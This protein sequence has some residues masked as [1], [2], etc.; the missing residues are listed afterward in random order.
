MVFAS[1]VLAVLATGTPQAVFE[2]E[3][4]KYERRPFSDL[5]LN[6]TGRAHPAV[7]GCSDFEI[8]RPRPHGGKVVKA[9]DFGLSQAHSNNA[10]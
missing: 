10:A 8:E 6:G 1:L 3:P 2:K 5:R 9:T 4:A 7:T